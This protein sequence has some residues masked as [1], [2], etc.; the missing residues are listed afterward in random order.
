M[1]TSVT[2]AVL[3]YQG[4]KKDHNCFFVFFLFKFMTKYGHKSTRLT[5]LCDCPS[6]VK[7]KPGWETWTHSGKY[8]VEATAVNVQSDVLAHVQSFL[9]RCFCG[10]LQWQREITVAVPVIYGWETPSMWSQCPLYKSSRESSISATPAL[11]HPPFLLY[12]I[13][14]QSKRHRGVNDTNP[15]FGLRL[16]VAWTSLR[17]KQS[18]RAECVGSHTHTHT[19]WTCSNTAQRYS[20]Q[21]ATWKKAYQRHMEGMMGYKWT[22][23]F[24]WWFHTDRYVR[25]LNE[26]TCEIFFFSHGFTYLDQPSLFYDNPLHR[27]VT[28]CAVNTVLVWHVAYHPRSGVS[29]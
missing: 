15:G 3:L 29:I 4:T 13:C 7:W 26:T 23:A 21:Q 6:S 5:R 19:A 22:Q 20:K 1:F 25:H 2:L 12:S 14:C 16:T 11:Y 17:G 18:K 24:L 9:W 10:M 8:W 27:F 28:L